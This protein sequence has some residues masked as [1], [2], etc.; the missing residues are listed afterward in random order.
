MPVSCF[1]TQ[2]GGQM[3]VE[4]IDALQQLKA[5]IVKHAMKFNDQLNFDFR[6]LLTQSNFAQL[7]GQLLWT[8]I[9]HLEP[10]V[11]VAPGYGAMPLAYAI[12]HAA[13]VEGVVLTVLMVRDKR[14]NY[15]Q[16]KWV[17]GHR[18]AAGTKAVVV[19]DFMSG[20]SALALVDNAL[21]ADAIELQLK[22]VAVFFD[23]WEPLGSRQI[24]LQRLPVIRLFTRHD[25]GL[26]RD[27]HDAR[28]PAMKG[29]AQDFIGQPLWWRM[30]LN[31]PSAY[32]YRSSPAI[33][34]NAVF[35]ADDQS[36][37]TRHNAWT[38]D[39][40]WVRDSLARPEKGIVQ[41]LTVHDNSLV[42]GCY[43]GTITR[44]DASTGD[45]IWR[46]RQDT[47]VHATPAIDVQGGR[48]FIN[49][50]QWNEGQPFGH[51]MA[52]DWHSGR[53]LWKHR[54]AWWPPGSPAWNGDNNT[55]VASCNDQTLI[56]CNGDTGQ[57]LWR[58]DTIGLVRGRPLTAFG[59]VVVATEKGWLH[60]FDLKTGELVW[61]NR[62]GQGLA[63]QF[64]AQDG[65]GVMVFDGK[66]HWACFD[67]NSGDLCWVTRLRSPGCWSPLLLSKYS[68]ALSKQGHLAVM[69]LEQKRKLW[70]GQIRGCYEQPPAMGQVIDPQGNTRQ[71]FA[72]ASNNAG[73]Q[74]FEIHPDYISK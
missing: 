13:L 26:S 72:A 37:I 14:K 55:V 18:P 16:K 57:M 19:D 21:Q 48:I 44:L 38:G 32:T 6:L 61:R 46:W 25:I 17:E 20:G 4:H 31:T 5:G 39:I 67:L 41:Q 43:D 59:K 65:T 51:L 60:C 10:Q 30:A 74:V 47:S 53:L 45:I 11:L 1:N 29:A 71:L 50:E 33:A 28:P 52:L 40:E 27:C 36:R 42:Y 24:Q 34:N 9:K 23:M 62:Y 64:L 69:D 63:H 68:I 35:V 58:Q 73:L 22:A 3:N 7:A 12:T 2:A 70:E 8:R 56:A 49:T 54:H 15:N 66:W